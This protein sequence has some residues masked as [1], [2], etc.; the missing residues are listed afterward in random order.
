MAYTTSE[1]KA[2]EEVGLPLTRHSEMTEP[3]MVRYG[4]ERLL[5]EPA[6]WA[7]WK[8]VGLVTN[9][10]ARLSRDPAQRTRVALLR[11]GV[12]LVRLFGPEHGLGAVAADG[13]AV[14]DGI[15]PHT[16]LPVRSLY[17]TQV[18]PSRSDLADLDVVLFDIPDVGARFYTYAWTL[19]HLV[20]ACADAAVPLVVLDR[21]NPLGG[22]LDAAEGPILD[23]SCR[24]FIGDDD[25]PVRHSLSLGELARLW[26][27][28]HAP[29]VPLE[30]IPCEG[31]DATRAWPATARM[32]VPTS[33]AMPSFESSIWY[34]GTC[35]FE[36]TNVSVGR[37]TEA[38]FT[39][40][41][42]PWC[43]AEALCQTAV[44]DG[45]QL[46]ACRFTPAIGPAAGERCAGV[47]L[48]VAPHAD[49]A[50]IIARTLR[51]VALGLTLLAAM[52]HRHPNAFAW[53]RYPTAVNPDGD[54]HLARLIGRRDIGE[55]LRRVQPGG[56]TLAPLIAQ[57]TTVPQWSTR[58]RPVLLYPRD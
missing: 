17:G 45:V 21:P 54:N 16:H 5:A 13:A 20:Q 43:D 57:W 2:V 44:P 56:D 31:W 19:Y 33:P 10:A 51:P 53:A 27:A 37:G 41:G 55:T 35:L 1:R 52:A 14:P 38:P 48:Q 34:P 23:L 58:V 24:S 47:R 50:A 49:Q 42:A 4:V 3:V 36:A 32:W 40:I 22:V 30:V 28:E 6:R 11:A 39:M 46:T 8:R 15:D 25:I 7:H 9:D 12:P 29:S 18:R 26:Q